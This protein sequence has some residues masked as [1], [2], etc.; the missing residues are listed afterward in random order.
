M[1][2]DAGQSDRSV[3]VDRAKHHLSGTCGSPPLHAGRDGRPGAPR[4]GRRRAGRDAVPLDVARAPGTGHRGGVARGRSR[5]SG[6]CSRG[7]RAGPLPGLAGGRRRGATPGRDGG[8]VAGDDARRDP[9]TRLQ[10]EQTPSEGALRALPRRGGVPQ[11][12]DREGARGPQHRP[13]CIPDQHRRAPHRATHGAR[14]RPQPA[15]LRGRGAGRSGR[16]P[17]PVPRSPRRGHA[18]LPR[19][20]GL[21]APARRRGPWHPGPRAAPHRAP[22]VVRGLRHRRRGLRARHGVPHGVRRAGEH[23]VPEGLRE[24]HEPPGPSGGVG[25]EVRRGRPR[26]RSRRPPRRLVRRGRRGLGGRPRGAGGGLLLAPQ[27]PPGPSVPATGPR[28]L[29]E[30]ADLPG[31]TGA[32]PGAR[33]PVHRAEAGRHPVPRSERGARGAGVGLRTGGAR[34]SG[35]SEDHRSTRPAPASGRPGAPR[36]RRGPAAPRG[37]VPAGARV[38]RAP[39]PVRPHRG[40]GGRQPRG[41]ALLRGRPP[42]APPAGGPSHHGRHPPERRAPSPCDL[43][44]ARRGG[45][46]RGPGA[47]PR[48]A[49]RRSGRPGPP[50]ARLRR[51]CGAPSRGRGRGV[52]AH[53]PGRRGAPR[54]RSRPGAG[55][56]R[57]RRRRRA[58]RDPRSRA[59]RGAG[60]AGVHD[61]G[62]GGRAAVDAG[63][64]RRAAPRERGAAIDH[65]GAPRRERG[66]VPGQRR[67][68]GPD[69]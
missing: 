17:G 45:H 1:H 11:P 9:S 61:P 42:P 21:H 54:S 38:R 55:V 16:A 63:P 64:Q 41:A 43:P 66:A 27:P 12:A 4:A 33:G 52:P 5:R 2:T 8:A 65:R 22:G 48:G 32:D 28:Q 25:G 56:R 19:P 58:H 44:G 60:R 40:P 20:G 6:R 59:R 23:A 49:G 3:H 26:A 69:W 46:R 14:A 53:A 10:C 24:R 62:A 57:R 7:G 36:R 35:L 39:G 37:R 30:P 51:R 47:G 50:G 18:V 67:A 31:P 13:W 29:P 34:S 68:P 15:R